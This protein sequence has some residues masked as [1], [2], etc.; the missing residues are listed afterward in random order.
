MLN[1]R[2]GKAY[3]RNYLRFG[4]SITKEQ[5]LGDSNEDSKI[6]TKEN[7]RRKRSTYYEH[8]LIESEYWLPNYYPQ[9]E[10][11]MRPEAAKR[12]Y[13]SRNFLRYGRDPLD[14]HFLRF[15]KRMQPSVHDDDR[16]DRESRNSNVKN[17]LRFG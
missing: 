2:Y 9:D 4:R 12:G 6:T 8:P 14:M 10:T 15:G 13:N 17:F 3:D 16:I 11:E 7:N 5:E 1:F